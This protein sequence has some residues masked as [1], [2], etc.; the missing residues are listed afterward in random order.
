MDYAVAVIVLSNDLSRSVDSQRKG[1]RSAGEI[2]VLEV[3]VGAQES[4]EREIGI[5]IDSN[6]VSLIVDAS[7]EGVCLAGHF[8]LLKNVAAVSETPEHVGIEEVTG[9]LPAIVDSYGFGKA[10]T[11]R[12]H[13][14]IYISE[15]SI[16]KH[17]SVDRASSGIIL[18]HDLTAVINLES[19]REDRA[20]RIERAQ[21]AV[22]Q[23]KSMSSAS[24]IFIA[25]DHIAPVIDSRA[26]SRDRA[27]KIESGK[28]AV[29]ASYIGMLGAQGIHIGA[30]NLPGAVDIGSD[31]TGGAWN[32]D[33]GIG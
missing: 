14:L 17:E 8:E 31:A 2:H 22:A 13:S 1:S 26:E 6:D 30:Y 20:G 11:I 32:I 18:A 5:N 15:R 25:A 9:D 10:E 23:Q 29:I 27:R 4:M 21:I 19:D 24:R 12:H 7:H 3:A 33:I 16:L 28:A